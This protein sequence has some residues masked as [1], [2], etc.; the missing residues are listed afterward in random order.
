MNR[1][2]Q[3][4]RYAILSFLAAI[5]TIGIKSVAYFLTGSVGLLS[6]ALESGVNLVAAVTAIVA[7]LYASKP[8]DEEHAYGHQKVEY[9]ATGVEGGLVIMAAA[10]ISF[11]AVQR[12]LNPEPLEQI[13]IGLFISL[14]ASIINLA[15]AVTLIRVGRAQRSI[16]L[17]ADGRHLMTDVWTSLGILFGVGVVALTGWEILDPI[18]ALIVA[19]LII[20]TGFRLLRRATLGLLDTSLPA[21]ALD[22]IHKVLDSYCSEGIQYH[23]LRSRQSGFRSFVSFQILVP[24]EWTVQESHDLVEDIEEDIRTAIPDITVF[25]HVEPIDDPRSWKDI[26]LDRNPY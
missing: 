14:S 21:A 9:L 23:A 2:S 20:L 1:R 19:I 3:L 24:G 4:V 6:D 13:N 5:L 7:I 16:A 17:E 15:V 11:A 22:R 25:T 12:L 8:P 18:V 10:S 26:S